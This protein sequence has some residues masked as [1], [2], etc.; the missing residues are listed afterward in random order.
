MPFEAVAIVGWLRRQC[1][2]RVPPG[3]ALVPSPPMAVSPD[4]LAPGG[5][6]QLRATLVLYA[7][8]VLFSLTLGMIM[9]LTPLYVLEIG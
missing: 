1:K 2:L 5:S 9:M 3:R 4:H 6:A 8:T 7:Q